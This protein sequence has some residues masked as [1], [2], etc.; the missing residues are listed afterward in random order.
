LQPPGVWG[1]SN[2]HYF[3]WLFPLFAVGTW[4]WLREFRSGRGAGRAIAVVAILLVPAAFRPMPV[5]VPDSVPARMLMFRGAA[6]RA[7]DSAYFAPATITDAKGTLINVGRFHQVPDAYGERAVAVWRLFDGPALRDDPGEA[8]PYKTAEMP[9]ARY[10]VRI[11]PGIPCWVSRQA[12]CR[13]P[14]PPAEGP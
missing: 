6:D 14:P 5:A 2:A 8:A 3:K 10:A 9:Y 12:V 11:S 13:M 1:F 7:W 4:L